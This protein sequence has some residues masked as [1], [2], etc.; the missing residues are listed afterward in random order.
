[1]SCS[2]CVHFL[3]VILSYWCF[4]PLRW[5]DAEHENLLYMRE[6]SNVDP[7]MTNIIRIGA[8]DNRRVSHYMDYVPLPP[9]VYAFSYR[10]RQKQRVFFEH[11]LSLH[12]QQ[13]PYSTADLYQYA[14]IAVC[15]YQILIHSI[16]LYLLIVLFPYLLSPQYLNEASLILTIYY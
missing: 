2:T 4:I 8:L 12:G 9:A 14:I 10:Q 3:I 16:S 13:R 1:M 7:E 6:A 15:K 11:F 5:H